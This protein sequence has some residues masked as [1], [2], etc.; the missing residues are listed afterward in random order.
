MILF[1]GSATRSERGFHLGRI[2]RHFCQNSRVLPTRITHDSVGTD[3]SATAKTK[4]RMRNQVRTREDILSCWT[5]LKKRRMWSLASM[6]SVHRVI[7]S[8][9]TSVAPGQL[10]PSSDATHSVTLFDGLLPHDWQLTVLLRNPSRGC[11]EA[12]PLRALHCAMYW[13]TGGK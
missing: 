6:S 4:N 9:Q 11:A 3:H 10:C 12:M 5:V 2:N 8:Q 13:G 7:G 1:K